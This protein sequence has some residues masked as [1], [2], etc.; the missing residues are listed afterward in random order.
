MQLAALVIQKWWYEAFTLPRWDKA[1]TRIQ[2]VYRGWAWAE[3]WVLQRFAA[4]LIQAQVRGRQSRL[5][6]A[7]QLAETRDEGLNVENDGYVSVSSSSSSSLSSSSSNASNASDEQSDTNLDDME[8][9]LAVSY[10]ISDSSHSSSGSASETPAA[11]NAVRRLIERF[12]T[13]L[14]VV[15]IVFGAGGIALD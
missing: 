6:R 4:T 5:V 3:F 14:P 2:A 11:R 10:A 12:M 13:D 7:R 1:A 9:L 15:G 8:P